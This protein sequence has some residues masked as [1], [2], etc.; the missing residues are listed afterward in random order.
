[1]VQKTVLIAEKKIPDALNGTQKNPSS[2]QSL[3]SL[4]I[5]KSLSNFS[6]LTKIVKIIFFKNIFLDFVRNYTLWIYGFFLCWIQCISTLLLSYQKQLSEICF[7]IFIPFNLGGV[8]KLP[9]ME[10]RSKILKQ[11]LKS[12][13]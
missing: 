10:K 3:V 2:L 13:G 6:F 1:M 11:G 9:D 4:K 7:K 8:K 5:K 12:G